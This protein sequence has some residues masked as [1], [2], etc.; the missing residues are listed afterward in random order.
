MNLID[1]LRLNCV[2]AHAD[3]TSQSDVLSKIA[4]LACKSPLLA[5]AG[6]AV[7]LKGLTE[8]E[9]LSTTGFGGRHCHSPLPAGRRRGLCRWH[10]I[11]AQGSRF[12]GHGRRAG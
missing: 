3:C 6:E 1:I 4:Q 10:F 11:R 2:E 7:L 9:E 12:C 8:R 5:N